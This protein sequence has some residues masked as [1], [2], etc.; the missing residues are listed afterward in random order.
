MSESSL[1]SSPL[2]APLM[3]LVW[4]SDIAVLFKI[5]VHL[6]LFIARILVF[7]QRIRVRPSPYRQLVSISLGR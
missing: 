4:S 7:P 5:H 3:K 1:Q 2:L 6:S